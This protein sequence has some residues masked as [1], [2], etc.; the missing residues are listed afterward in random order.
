MTD[1]RVLGPGLA[2]TPFTAEEIREGCPEGRTVRLRVEPAAGESHV[3]VQ[4]FTDCDRDGATFERSRV[5]LAGELIGE[6]EAARM[7]WLNLQRHAAFPR[8]HTTIEPELL[9]L[10][11]GD[12]ECLRYTV[13]RDGA[14]AVFWFARSLPGMPVKVVTGPRSGPP[15]ETVVMISDEYA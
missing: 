1:P 14:T 15:E 4:R 2:P 11:V 8:A 5:S 9:R 10:P 7:S 13:R 12:L 6:V 3:R